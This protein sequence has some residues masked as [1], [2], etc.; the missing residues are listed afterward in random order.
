MNKHY[1]IF[2]VF[3]HDDN[4]FDWVVDEMKPDKNGFKLLD[5]KNLQKELQKTNTIHELWTDSKC[6]L[7]QVENENLLNEIFKTKYIVEIDTNNPEFKDFISENSPITIE[8]FDKDEVKKLVRSNILRC[9]DRLV[10]KETIK[11]AF[12]L[13]QLKKSII[14]Y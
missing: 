10:W 12:M 8:A 1:Q 9:L 4:F 2:S 14:N 6:L 7:I 3:L 13:S 11:Q 5:Y